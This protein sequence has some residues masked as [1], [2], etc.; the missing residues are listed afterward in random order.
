M[1]YLSDNV[2]ILRF[3]ESAG[4]LRKAIS[5][6]KKRG[7]GHEDTIRELSFSPE[8]INIGEPLTEFEGVLTGAP[9]YFGS[10]S[11]KKSGSDGQRD[12]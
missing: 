11:G 2:L 7:G 8:G 6:V 9:S 1:S 4:R 5:V 12:S 3:F 10:T